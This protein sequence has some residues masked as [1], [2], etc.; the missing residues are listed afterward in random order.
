MASES[1]LVASSLYIV[2]SYAFDLGDVSPLLFI[3]S[4]TK[5]CGK[6]KL[7]SVLARLVHR[8]LPTSS[9]SAA[10]IYRTIELHKPTL[11]IDEVDAFLKGDE[12]LRGLINS[13]H[14]RDAAFHLCCVP[15]GDD[16]QPRRWSTWAPKILSGLGRLAG[17]L[18]DRA[19]IIHMRRRRKDEEVERLRFK[20]RFEDLRSQCL[21]FVKDNAQ[22]IRE[23]EPDIPKVLNDRAADNWT[24][25]LILADLAGGD[26]P[27]KARQ[28]ARELSGSDDA[29]EDDDYSVS[30]LSD[31][32]TVFG[33]S[34][35]LTFMQTSVLLQRLHQ[36]DERPWNHYGENPKPITDRQLAKLLKPFGIHSRDKRLAADEVQ[37]DES[38]VRKGYFIE[39]FA[40]AF[41]SYLPAPESAVRDT[42]TTPENADDSAPIRSATSKTRSRSENEESINKAG[43]CSVVADERQQP[44]EG[45]ERADAIIL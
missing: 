18:Q 6:T 31:I 42:A 11:L 4:P 8:P 39:D 7:F 5:R 41:A 25:L 33:G 37:A 38:P 1:A 45:H 10:G 20:T 24:P 44:S 16:Y 15:I 14:T 2:H 21:R 13:G 26:W 23:G 43:V 32:R 3:T 35:R 22:A 19:V 30:A 27:A 28:A 40:E 34:G 36:L 17:T 29:D 12:Q 9:A